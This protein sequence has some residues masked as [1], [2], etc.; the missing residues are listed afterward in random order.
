MLQLL[1]KRLSNKYEDEI[2]IAMEEQD[3]ITQ[4]RL[5]KLLS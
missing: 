4:L 3:K 1:K 2:R 5:Q